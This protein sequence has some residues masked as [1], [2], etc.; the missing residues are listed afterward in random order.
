MRFFASLAVVLLFCGVAYA[1]APTPDAGSGV[2]PPTVAVPASE[3][4]VVPAAPVV[5]PEAAPV[6]A[7]D[8]APTSTVAPVPSVPTS[9]AAPAPVTDTVAP[10]APA[11]PSAPVAVPTTDQEA[12]GIL[13]QMIDAS[14]NGHWNVA[15]GLLV[16]LLVWLFNRLGLAAKVGSKFVPWVALVLG[17]ITAVAVG[18]AQGVPLAGAV[19]AGLLNGALAVALWELVAKHFLKKSA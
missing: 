3:P 18:L 1:Q 15:A 14:K 19:Q 10:A 5:A 2:A 9:T 6:V 8:S 7:P 12:G 13:G 4:V 11:T 17:A 16:L